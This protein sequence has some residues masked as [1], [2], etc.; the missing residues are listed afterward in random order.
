MLNHPIQ[1]WYVQ[2]PLAFQPLVR[3][4]MDIITPYLIDVVY[5]QG[6]VRLTNTETGEY[7]IYGNTGITARATDIGTDEGLF[8]TMPEGTMRVRLRRNTFELMDM[9]TDLCYLATGY[10]GIVIEFEDDRLVA[11]TI[12][13]PRTKLAQVRQIQ[14][15]I[16]KAATEQ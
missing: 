10:W 14:Y 9:R 16:L 15:G 4:Y 2:T 3:T 11:N 7:V 8:C 5:S 12:L 1:D 13:L 6:R